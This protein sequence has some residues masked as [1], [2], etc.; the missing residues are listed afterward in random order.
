MAFGAKGAAFGAV[1]TLAAFACVAL[2]ELGH[3]LV[4]KA[5]GVPVDTITLTPLGG[6]AHLRTRPRTP[7]QELLIAVAGPAVNGVLA[8]AFVITGLWLEGPDAL[9]QAAATLLKQP[10]RAEHIWIMLIGTNVGLMLFNLLP[11]LPMDGGRILRAL[12][13]YVLSPERATTIAATIARII[14]VLMFGAALAFEGVSPVL[15]FI[16]IMV[17]FAAGAEVREVKRSQWLSQIAS[18]DAVSPF[19]PRL[20]LSTPLTQV[21]QLLVRSPYRVFAVE[22]EGVFVGIVTAESV[23]RALKKGDGWGFVS[24]VVDERVPL[25]QGHQSLET[26]RTQMALSESRAVAVFEGATFLGLLTPA[27]L[28]HALEMNARLRNGSAA[29]SAQSLW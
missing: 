7:T 24:S 5:F 22:R 11:A 1:M 17:F 19:A 9:N 12:L 10:P 15:P 4:A 20:Q 3:S 18:R 8:V 25:M 28:S 2:H 13:S 21:V 6:V 26:A 14:A 27:E 29:Q 16:A 23:L